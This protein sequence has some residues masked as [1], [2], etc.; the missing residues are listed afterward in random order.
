MRLAPVLGSM[1]VGGASE[2]SSSAHFIIGSHSVI[3]TVQK[4]YSARGPQARPQQQLQLFRAGRPP[5]HD[6]F[7][8]L[9]E[10]LIY[11]S[12]TGALY[13]AQPDRRAPGAGVLTRIVLIIG[14]Q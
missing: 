11:E 6:C 12:S 5:V 1:T 4:H 3:Q 9:S 2:T 13:R 7:Q 8:S 14:T 10:L